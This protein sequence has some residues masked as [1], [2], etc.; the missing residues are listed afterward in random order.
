MIRELSRTGLACQTRFVAFYSDIDHLIWPRRNARIE[1]PDLK[2]RNIEAPGVGH[3]SMPNNSRI[4]FTIA[5]ALREL[6][7][8]KAAAGADPA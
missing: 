2:A 5:S 6:D 1:H 4:A 3:L 7:P 8:F